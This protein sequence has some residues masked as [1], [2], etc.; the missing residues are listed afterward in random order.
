MRHLIEFRANAT[1]LI[2][3]GGASVSI[4]IRAG[5]QCPATVHC[6]VAYHNNRYVEVA[7]IEVKEGIVRAL[8]CARF[9]FIDRL[10]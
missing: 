5:V 8:P 9:M 2:E 6:Y 7:D 10:G 1:I 3:R 4:N